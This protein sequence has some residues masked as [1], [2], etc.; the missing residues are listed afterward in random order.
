MQ[1]QSTEEQYVYYNNLQ[2]KNDEINVL[3]TELKQAQ[4]QIQVLRKTMEQMLKAEGGGAKD[5]DDFEY[6]KR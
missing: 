3:K 4:S 6:R 5:L 2:Y 1:Q